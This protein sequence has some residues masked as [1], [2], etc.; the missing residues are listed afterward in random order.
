M[1]CENSRKNGVIYLE[2][3]LLHLKPIKSKFESN[4]NYIETDDTKIADI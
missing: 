4:E 2:Y 3:L 1:E